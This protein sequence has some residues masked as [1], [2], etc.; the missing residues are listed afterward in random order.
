MNPIAQ[1]SKRRSYSKAARRRFD[2]HR[3]PLRLSPRKVVFPRGL[4]SRGI[5]SHNSHFRFVFSRMF[6][7]T[8][9]VQFHYWIHF[10]LETRGE[11]W[12]KKILALELVSYRSILSGNKIQYRGAKRKSSCFQPF[13]PCIPSIRGGEGGDFFFFTPAIIHFPQPRYNAT[14]RRIS[15]GTPTFFLH[16][17]LSFS[18]SIV[19]N[20]VEFCPLALG[21]CKV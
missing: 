20:L 16:F 14:W 21:H 6:N 8:R 9:L 7:D 18:P 12:K 17:L 4:R 15:F 13:L 11:I 10:R 1:L 2:L 19:E 3:F 5:N